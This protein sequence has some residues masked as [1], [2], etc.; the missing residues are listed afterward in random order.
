MILAG[1]IYPENMPKKEFWVNY[2]AQLKKEALVYVPGNHDYYYKED[3]MPIKGG[4]SFVKDNVR[5]ICATLWTNF[6]DFN[7]VD[8]LIAERM[9]WDFEK[10]GITPTQMA[11]YYEQDIEFIIQELNVPHNG[12]TIIVTH[13]VPDTRFIVKSNNYFTNNALATII[14]SNCKM[15]NYWIFGHSHDPVNKIVNGVHFINNPHLKGE[16]TWKEIEIV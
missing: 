3:S 8:M 5:F 15:P 16:N 13:F 14:K 1:D 7:S 12:P 9:F 2:A 10:I 6:G 4:W 11:N